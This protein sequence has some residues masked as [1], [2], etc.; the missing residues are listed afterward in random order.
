MMHVLVEAERKPVHFHAALLLWSGCRHVVRAEIFVATHHPGTGFDA[1]HGEVNGEV[2]KRKPPH[3]RIDEAD[4]RQCAQCVHE[5]VQRQRS[6][7]AGLTKLALHVIVL[8][9]EVCNEVLEVECEPQE[10]DGS[11]HCRGVRL[12]AWRLATGSA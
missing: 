3:R 8:Q 2:Q 1:V 7:P 11:D 4:D 5:A 6:S 10:Q 9:N 12:V